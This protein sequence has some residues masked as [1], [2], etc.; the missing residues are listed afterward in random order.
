MASGA[1]GEDWAEQAACRVG[2]GL[3]SAPH[4]SITLPTAHLMF[5]TCGQRLVRHSGN[6]QK[7]REP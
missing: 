4:S 7:E 2:R 3:L 1:H 5:G 6:D